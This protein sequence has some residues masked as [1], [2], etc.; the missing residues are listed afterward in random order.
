MS[1]VVK[2]QRNG[3][4]HWDVYVGREFRKWGYNFDASPWGNPFFLHG[5]DTRDDILQ[6]YETYIRERLLKEPALFEQFLDLRGKTLGCWCKPKPCHG[7]VLVKIMRE[8]E[9]EVLARMASS[10]SARQ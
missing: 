3:G 9:A 2:I 1:R 10:P 7:D 4:E 5:E 8:L 6:K